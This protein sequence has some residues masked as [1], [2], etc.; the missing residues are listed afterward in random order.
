[1]YRLL[2][3]LL[4]CFNKERER[5]HDLLNYHFNINCYTKPIYHWFYTVFHFEQLLLYIISLKDIK[6]K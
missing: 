4:L 2:H 1:M 5:L 3:S 6:K